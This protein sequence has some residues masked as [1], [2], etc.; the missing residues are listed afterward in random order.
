MKLKKLSLITSIFITGLVAI[1]LPQSALAAKSIQANIFLTE[2]KQI[3]SQEKHDEIYFHIIDSDSQHKDSYSEANIPAF[4]YNTDSN[5]VLVP[6]GSH[7]YWDNSELPEVK[8]VLLWKKNILNDG[9]IELLISLVEAD[10]PPW[11]VD[12]TLGTVKVV[13]FNRSGMLH[14]QIFPQK[15]SAISDKKDIENGAQYVIHV[16][17]RETEYVYILSIISSV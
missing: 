14:I 7:S 3:Q 10:T 5:S 13:V 15:N 12:D 11:D 8:S 9:A 6:R 2:I 17:D 1:F 4:V 16:K